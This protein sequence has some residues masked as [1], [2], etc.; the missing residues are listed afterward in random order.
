MNDNNLTLLEKYERIDNVFNLVVNSVGKIQYVIIKKGEGMHFKKFLISNA[1]QLT[2]YGDI[3]VRFTG[4]VL[5][6]DVNLNAKET[7]SFLFRE[8]DLLGEVVSY[9]QND[10]NDII[11]NMSL[12]T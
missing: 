7:K 12:N 10:V 8:N 11:K 5:R 2:N 9:L 3:D 4:D 6:V 1:D